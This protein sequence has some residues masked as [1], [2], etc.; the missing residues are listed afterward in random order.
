MQEFRWY[1]AS[2][3]AVALILTGFGG[4]PGAVSPGPS[5]VGAPAPNQA[6]TIET[7]HTGIVERVVDGDTVIVSGLGSVRLIGVDTPETVHPN[8]LVEAFGY[9]ASTFLRELVLHQQVRIEYDIQ[10]KDRYNRTLA[11]LYLQDGR[12]V[13]A[14]IVR[15]GFGHAYTQF[16]FRYL[17][18]FRQLEREAREQKRGLWRDPQ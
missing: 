4:S 2:T 6:A 17:D 16:P 7:R 15:E 5:P 13:N 10:R 14:A 11:Y 8:G 3:V 9:E 12:F 18:E 1:R